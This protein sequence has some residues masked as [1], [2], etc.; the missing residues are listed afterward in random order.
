MTK[1]GSRSVAGQRLSAQM[2]PGSGKLQATLA[3]AMQQ[4]LALYSSRDWA[5]AEQ[6]CGM[7]VSAQATHF[8]ALNLLGIIA[9]QTQ[10]PREAVEFLGRAAGQRRDEPTVHN[11]YGNVLRDLERHE[12][13]L[14]SYNRAIQIKPDYAQAHYNRGLTLQSLKRF[15]DALAS[16]DVAIKLSPGHAAAHNNRGVT[17]RE[18]KRLDEALAGCDRAIALRPD[19]APAYNNRG[20]VLQELRRTQDA[21]DSYAKALAINAD[22][23]EAL[24]NQGNA[25][26]E[27]QRFDAALNS[28]QRALAISPNYADAHSSHGTALQQLNR[29]QE[30]LES[31][32]RAIAINPRHAQAHYNRGNTLRTLGLHD[33]ALE[34][35][36]RALDIEPDF[37]DAPYNRGTILHELKRFNDALA[38]FERAREIDPEQPWLPGICLHAKARICDWSDYDSRLAELTYRIR[39]GKPASPPFV[40]VTMT[41]SLELQRRAGEIFIR[42]TCPAQSELPPPPKRARRAKIRIGYFSADYYNHATIILAGGLFERHDR[43][44]FEIVA[45][46]FGSTPRDEVTE[47]LA[48]AFDQFIDV[49]AQ[50]DLQIAE[51][52]REMEVDIAVDLKGFT[53]HQRAG[54]F[55]RRAAPIQVNYLGYPGT[56]GAPFIDYIIADER[57]IP[58]G[59]RGQYAESGVYLT[60][61]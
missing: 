40:V 3:Q 26:R 45:F 29:H 58:Q 48:K 54:V 12:E 14:R 34:S 33:L 15:G 9:A 38:S 49:R 57:V 30:A 18:L 23:A 46:N 7:I 5:K 27:Q 55:A 50:T 41:D 4:A 39:Q 61:S 13:A 59:S 53:L 31:F 60:G 25:L 52:S 17:L 16:Y 42:E 56:L 20:V 24:H 10:R 36:E 47:R 2:R 1:R 6:V 44:R 37:A 11:N 32:E 21:L 28:F 22:Y 35:Y 51:L 43:D 8:D 19:Y